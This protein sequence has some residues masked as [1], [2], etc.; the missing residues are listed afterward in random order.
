MHAYTEQSENADHQAAAQLLRLRDPFDF[1]CNLDLLA[2]KELPG[3]QGLVPRKPIVFAVDG[4]LGGKAR[5]DVA[6]WVFPFSMERQVKHHRLLQA[7]D[8][9][10]IMQLST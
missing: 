7:V 3:F 10:E 6:P 2:D 8:R 4:G 1:Q 9:E 5:A